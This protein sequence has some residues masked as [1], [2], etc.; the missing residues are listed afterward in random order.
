MDW[1]ILVTNNRII[2]ILVTNNKIVVQ[3]W[4]FLLINYIGDI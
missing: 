4:I 1:V 2:V 3:Y